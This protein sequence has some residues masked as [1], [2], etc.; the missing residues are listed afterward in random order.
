MPNDEPTQQKRPGRPRQ[1]QRRQIISISLSPE[2]VEAL[3]AVTDNTSAFIE[4]VLREHHEIAAQ[5]LRQSG[6]DA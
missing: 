5:L 4:Q 3:T 6:G 2:V 1:Q